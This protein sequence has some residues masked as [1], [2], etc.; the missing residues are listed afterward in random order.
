MSFV[1]PI[2]C[3]GMC[4]A[5]MFSIAFWSAPVYTKR[6]DPTM[7]LV[8]GLLLTRRQFRHSRC[9]SDGAWSDADGSDSKFTPFKSKGS[10]YAVNGGFCR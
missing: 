3:I 7:G 2:L 4:C 10:S 9:I 1:V 6:S 5:I 8:L